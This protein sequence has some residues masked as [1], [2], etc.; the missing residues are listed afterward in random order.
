MI[1]IVTCRCCEMRQERV[2]E[3]K[4][5]G[6]GCRCSGFWCV[7]S[8]KCVAHCPGLLSA[9]HACISYNDVRY[10]RTFSFDYRQ[11]IA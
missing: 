3:G 10:E 8:A 4:V 7:A 6:P 2:Y 11:D 5:T 9:K 1:E